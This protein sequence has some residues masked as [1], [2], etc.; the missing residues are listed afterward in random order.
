MDDI[1]AELYKAI[2][3][4]YEKEIKSNPKIALLIK[5]MKSEKAGYEDAM[6]FAGELGHCLEKAF[7]KNINADVLPGGKMPNI[8][9]KEIIGP[10][11]KE[12]YEII[13]DQCVN[14]QY[15]LN[16]AADIGLKGIKP[17]YNENKT[18]GIINYVSDKEYKKI[19]KSFLDSLTTNSRSVVDDSVKQNAEFHFQSGLSPKIVRRTSGKCCKWCQKIAGVYNYSDIRNSGNDVFRRHANCNC[20]VVYDPGNGAKQVQN[21]WSKNWENRIN[22]DVIKNRIKRIEQLE[23]K[24]YL[25]KD[26]TKQYISSSTP[27]KGKI[28][29]E[30]G[31]KL[32]K[33]KQEI[34]VADL[35]HS[36]FGGDIKLLNESNISGEMKADFLWNDKLWDLKSV[37]TEKSADSAIRKGLKQIISNPGGIILDYRSKNIDMDKL[38][39]IV[40]PRMKR[41]NHNAADIMIILDD[42]TLK[43]F[44]Y[45]K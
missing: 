20:T 6:D 19:E 31:Y 32:S 13:A 9:A 40:D 27:G 37:S 30:E 45:N 12:N 4:T 23:P 22:T 14:V 21:V 16:K 36:V 43:I 42:H 2:K 25:G 41:G 33:H 11:L 39:N 24:T 7:S 29:Y 8:L 18:N 10:I 38:M 35:I 5:K 1:S 28:E 44:R 34:E 3:D 15:I 26:V 17:T